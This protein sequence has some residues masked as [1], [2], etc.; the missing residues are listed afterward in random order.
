MT[1]AALRV[2]KQ[3]VRKS[4]F[5]LSQE[6]LRS[7]AAESITGLIIKSID[8][9][10]PAYVSVGVRRARIGTEHTWVVGSGETG[11]KHVTSQRAV[12]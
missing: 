2:L 11:L 9:G 6:W 5:G 4:R 12:I 3:P 10:L 7:S 1:S 8:L